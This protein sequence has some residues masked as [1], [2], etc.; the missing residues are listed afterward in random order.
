M[1]DTITSDPGTVH[2]TGELMDSVEMLTGDTLIV[3]GGGASEVAPSA[4]EASVADT[5]ECVGEASAAAVVSAAEAV[6]AAE[7]VARVG[8]ARAGTAKWLRSVDR[9][10][11]TPHTA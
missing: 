11:D 8:E 10:S 3:M 7:G 4:A 1:A 2:A 9:P 6:S 5:V